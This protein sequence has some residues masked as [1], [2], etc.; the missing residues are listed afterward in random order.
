MQPSTAFPT[1]PH[2]PVQPGV[3]IFVWLVRLATVAAFMTVIT[4]AAALMV[5]SAFG[6]R[7]QGKI[8]PGV[9]AWGIDL[10]GQ[11]P[12]AAATTLTGVFTYPS[13]PAFIFRDGDPQSTSTWS[14]TPAQLGL[15]FD[16]GATVSAAYDIGRSGNLVVDAWDMLRAWYG[17]RQVSP[18]VIY[19]EAQPINFLNQIAPEVYRPTVE[20]TLQADGVNITT[21][22]GSI[23]RQLDVLATA[24]Q[25]RPALLGLGGADI[26]LVFIETP[27]L[28]LDASAQAAAAQA[29]VR[30]PLTLSIAQPQEGDPGP[31]VVDPA[32]L[33]AMLE[34]R[35]VP[36][37]ENAAH[38]EVGLSGNA[39]RA[40]LQPLGE[41]LEQT[42]QNARFIFNTDT[43]QLE[44][45]EASRAGRHLDV[46]ATIAA[47]ND[48]LAAGSHAVP[49]VFV[50]TPPAAADTATAA[51]LGITQLVSE[52]STYFVGSST[53][54][55]RNIQV[56]GARF[57]GLLVPPNSE[58]SFNE[59]LGDV[60]LD[61]GFAE[62]LIIFGGR[63]IRGVGGGVCQVSTTIFRAAYF[64]GFPIVERY[65][66]AY[67]V[68]YYERGDTWRGPGLDA[69]VYSPLVDFKFT[70]DSPAWLLME[71]YVNPAAS[72][73]T[74]QFYSTSDGRSTTVS[75]A[76]VQ[77][78]VPAP[79]PLYEEDPTLAAGQIKQVDYAAD[80]ADVAITRV[81]M[82][83]GAQVNSGEPPLTTHYQPWRAVFNYGPGTEGIPPPAP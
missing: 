35:R 72:R 40:Y 57:H 36:D 62:A 51:E 39:L 43:S 32:A 70:N 52:Q 46:D 4:F 16:L 65:S 38:Y 21:T 71:V 34:V 30:E 56:A 29:I 66:H 11:S 37:G 60:S 64:G 45:L 20:A 17:G 9:S 78:V 63:T 42:A 75:E 80:G 22:P 13:R 74:W 82:R 23:G 18:V 53:E 54:R 10:S 77:N 6:L 2:E 28:V 7:Y 14:A 19:D 1:R 5:A 47:I 44:L 49:L 50:I 12:A 58:F 76:N 26:T 79:E 41:P 69:T 15:R 73:I 83:D 24:A 3:P 59:Y 33:G 61:S 68:S 55:I 81:I 25:V 67:R 27:P 48:A 31:W 8:Y